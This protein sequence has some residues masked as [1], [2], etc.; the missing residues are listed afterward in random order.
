MY[1][2]TD[3]YIRSG[4]KSIFQIIDTLLGR[5]YINSKKNY[6][7]DNCDCIEQTENYTSSAKK[8]IF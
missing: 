2:Y 3:N 7:L 1:W 6:Y 5:N 8:Y 4:K